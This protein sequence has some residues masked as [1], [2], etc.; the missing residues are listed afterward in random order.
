MLNNVGRFRINAT[1]DGTPVIQKKVN[2]ASNQSSVVYKA[3]RK[4]EIANCPTGI[5]SGGSTG[6]SP[7]SGGGM[8][9][10]AIGSNFIPSVLESF[11]ISDDLTRY[12]LFKD[13][14]YNDIIS[15]ATIDLWSHMPF[16]DFSLT[17]P[18]V[19]S[20]TNDILYKFSQSL[21]NLR[22]LSF[23]KELTIDYLALGA[24][25][26]SL[27]FDTEKKIYS[28]LTPFPVEDCTINPVPQYGVD[29]IVDAELP[30]AV[31]WVM[32]NRTD[33]RLT[34]TIESLPP[35]F[36]DIKGGKLK[37]NPENLLYINRRTRASNS[38]PYSFLTRA[39]P[40]YL[41]E[42][43]LL[44]G[45]IETAYKRQRA[46]THV[47]MGD[48]DWIPTDAELKD[49]ANAVIM[50]DL[51]PTGAVVATRDSVNFSEF[52]DVG[53]LW[54][55]EDSADTLSTIKMRALCTSDAF[56][57]GEA[58]FNA[59]DQAMSVT[60]EQ[61]KAFRDML[62]RKVIYGKIFLIVAVANGFTKD[63]Y[64]SPDSSDK[65]PNFNKKEVSS[66]SSVFGDLTNEANPK[67][68]KNA[69]DHIIPTLTWRKA[70]MP[71]GDTQY[72]ELLNGLSEKGL[73]IS[74][75]MLA[76]AGGMNL[77]DLV[78]GMADDVKLRTKIMNKWKMQLPKDPNEGNEFASLDL[79]DDNKLKPVGIL[80]RDY[81]AFEVRDPDTGKVLSKRARALQ[82]E[83]ANKVAAEVLKERAE[84]ENKK[85]VDEEERARVV[86]YHYFG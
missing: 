51:D 9:G 78:D 73:P 35:E 60:I 39:A 4:V 26:S 37:I 20:E 21:E 58:N 44:R 77:N 57:S 28:A 70:L 67:E 53:G 86:T 12:R 10:T 43:A 84:I 18:D 68:V 83:K 15:G 16:S 30:D 55:Y 23:F 66:F 48:M 3:S 62:M 47:Q 54:K 6:I 11:G 36:K 31:K 25:I 41:L 22:I 42:K 33:P 64:K 56:L 52:R 1:A 76:A 79:Y 45:T 8:S 71:E 38:M 5:S 13:M 7:A 24:S 82:D 40:L 81:S 69:R 34:K 50:A 85:I 61:M 75:R 27:H 80:N 17:L 2:T 19:G 74:L 14:Y 49:V 72:L 29:P 63:K 59:Y 46:I 32:A 65:V